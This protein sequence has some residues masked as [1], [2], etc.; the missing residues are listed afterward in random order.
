V[1]PRQSPVPSR[2]CRDEPGPH[3][4]QRCLES[5][6]S[7]QRR[8]LRVPKRG[9]RNDHHCRD[10]ADEYRRAEDMEEQRH[11]ECRSTDRSK[12][13]AW[14]SRGQRSSPAPECSRLKYG[15][16]RAYRAAS[17]THAREAR[18]IVAAQC[19]LL[20]E[21]T[22]RCALPG[23]HQP[24]LA[25]VDH[26][27]ELPAIRSNPRSYWDPAARI[28]G[29]GRKRRVHDLR[30]DVVF[31]TTDLDVKQDG[32]PPCNPPLTGGGAEDSVVPSSLA[33]SLSVHRAVARASAQLAMHE[34]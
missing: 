25:K 31:K 10:A 21:V 6:S 16:R 22:T 24:I 26:R 2:H 27:N 12:C 23:R 3:D 20:R 11:A 29:A 34:W 18:V 32:L 15:R 5:D 33:K 9:H 8:M 1:L 4:D 30:A 28:V 13:Q 19:R 14:S 7:Q 17:V